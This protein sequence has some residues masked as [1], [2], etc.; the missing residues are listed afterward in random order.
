LAAAVLLGVG[1][2]ACLI[3]GLRWIEAATVP[4]TR[5]RV[6]GLFY[7]FTYLGFAAPLL[8]AAW[9][10]RLGDR[11]SLAWAAV[12]ALATAVEVARGG[13]RAS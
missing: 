5:G 12:L 13:L 6:T 8:L 9:A 1:Y 7:V 3:A 2:G 10:P 11:V 4:A